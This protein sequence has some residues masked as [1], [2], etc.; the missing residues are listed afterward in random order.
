MRR[1]YS[2]TAF[3]FAECLP[4]ITDVPNE[5]HGQEK[6]KDQQSVIRESA[7]LHRRADLNKHASTD[8]LISLVSAVGRMVRP[9]RRA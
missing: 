3:R 2:F 4:A 5:G 1:Q 7:K 9:C 6:L 8:R